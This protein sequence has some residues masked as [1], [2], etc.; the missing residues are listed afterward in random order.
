MIDIVGEQNYT[1]LILQCNSVFKG[2]YCLMYLYLF[3]HPHEVFRL[4]K[5]WFRDFF[6]FFET[7]FL[8]HRKNIIE[9]FITFFETF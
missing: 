4:E 5:V 7:I 9:V 8:M 6:G 3:R 1:Y 2:R